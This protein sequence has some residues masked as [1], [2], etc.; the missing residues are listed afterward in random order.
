[1]TEK[2][3]VPP[4]RSIPSERAETR[5]RHLVQEIVAEARPAA[6]VPARGRRS[7]LVPA[8]GIAAA[9]A[10]A[11]IAFVGVGG[12]GAETASAATVLREAAAVARQQSPPPQPGAGDYLYVRS[13]SGYLSVYP[14]QG[15][16]VLVP[17]VREIWLGPDGGRLQER[18]SDPIFLSER[19]RERWIAA[20]RPDLAE[21]GSS[22]SLPAAEPLR[23]PGDADAL[24]ERLESEV[25][26]HSEGVHEQMFTLVGDALRE[27]SATPAQRAALYEVAARIPGVELL[28]DVTD[29]AGRPGVAVAMT[30]EADG[31]RQTLVFD[32]GTSALLAEEQRTLADN[33][34]GYPENT[35][36]GYATYH[37]TALVDS[38]RERP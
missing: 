36:V 3:M 20:G 2:L 28:G 35:V 25:A 10:A 22:T 30:N 24:Y 37:E 17:R 18:S 5:R 38:K 12:N 7:W 4:E 19:D 27:T 34:F 33:E 9:A 14:E 15:W 13:V 8:G 29:P 32:P 1:M 6:R 23:L 21:P 11:V 26:G 16:A 31:M